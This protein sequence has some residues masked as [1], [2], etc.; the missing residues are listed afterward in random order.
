M[1]WMLT[2]KCRAWSSLWQTQSSTWTSTPASLASTP[3]T[4]CTL[5]H[6]RAAVQ[7]NHPLCNQRLFVSLSQCKGL[8][9]CHVPLWQGFAEMNVVEE[10]VWRRLSDGTCLWSLDIHSPGVS[11]HVVVF[12]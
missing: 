7:Q 3:A 8:T 11:S 4:S 12:R 10:G 5:P 9:R 1:S 2:C 6:R